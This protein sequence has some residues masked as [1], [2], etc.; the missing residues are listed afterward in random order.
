[1]LGLGMY[2][3][4][5]LIDNYCVFDFSI[6]KFMRI[7]KVKVVKVEDKDVAFTLTMI[8]T[9]VHFHDFNFKGFI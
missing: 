4:L 2:Y 7:R 9:N 3:A 1:M 5:L 8:H 6:F